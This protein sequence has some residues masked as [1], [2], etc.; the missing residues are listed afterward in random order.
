MLHVCQRSVLL[1][2]CHLLT[3][4]H[5]PVEPEPSPFA[6]ISSSGDHHIS[7]A[8]PTEDNRDTQSGFAFLSESPAPSADT[9]SPPSQEQ[10]HHDGSHTL[11]ETQTIASSSPTQSPSPSLL[12]AVLSSSPRSTTPQQRVQ[13]QAPPERGK[14]IKRKAARPGQARSSEAYGML[15]DVTDSPSQTSDLRSST[16]NESGSSTPSTTELLSPSHV[17]AVNTED[18]VVPKPEAVGDSQDTVVSELPPTTPPGDSSLVPAQSS[19]PTPAKPS[20][21][22]VAPVDT[23]NHDTEES[24]LAPTG[25]S[26]R[27]QESLTPTDQPPSTENTSDPAKDTTEAEMT[28]DTA[29]TGTSASEDKP[30]SASGDSAVATPV[31]YTVE[32]SIIEKLETALEAVES[33]LKHVRYMYMW[34]ITIVHVFYTAYMYLVCFILYI[35]SCC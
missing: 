29:L 28:G 5:D 8:A 3:A 7:V 6:F 34:W 14:K 22:T 19:P 18:P 15:V 24:E 13:R 16:P 1:S 33:N 30:A 12:P 25:E 10:Q 31:N 26:N 9:V 27:P 20:A 32:L 17:S 4:P 11:Q 21:T 35:I 2:C 23:L